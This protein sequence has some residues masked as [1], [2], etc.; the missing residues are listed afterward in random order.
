MIVYGNARLVFSPVQPGTVRIAGITASGHQE[1][2]VEDKESFR[3]WAGEVR[4][5]YFDLTIRE[6]R[7]GAEIVLWPEAA[8]FGYRQDEAILI[9]N[10]EQAKRALTITSPVCILAD[11]ASHEVEVTRAEFEDATYDLL[12]QTRMGLEEVLENAQA[13]H[14]LSRD[15]I[16]ILLVGGS[17]KM[18]MVKEMIED[19]TGR[20]PLQHGNPDLLVSMGAAYWAHLRATGNIMVR[21]KDSE[22]KLQTTAVTA[23][24]DSLTTVSHYSVGVEACDSTDSSR[25]CNAVVLPKGSSFGEAGDAA[26]TFYKVSMRKV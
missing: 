20:P 10:C 14:G 12:Q 21:S 16:D 23:D 17:S 6:A 2:T 9:D 8:T 4:E 3:Q 22:G 25:M 11:S 24:P 26:R 7:A 1:L 13:E 15:A 19:V 5:S 18:P